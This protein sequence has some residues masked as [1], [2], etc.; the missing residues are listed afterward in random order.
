MSS[1]VVYRASGQQCGEDLEPFVKHPAAHPRVWL[2]AE[3]T[4]LADPVV[5]QPQAEHEPATREHRQ[6]GCLPG[7]DL[8]SAPRQRGHHRPEQQP[9]GPHRDGRATGPHVGDRGDPL[10]V[11]HVVPDEEPVPAGRL[12]FG[13]Q[14]ADHPWVGQGIEGGNEEPA[15]RGHGTIMPTAPGCDRQRAVAR[16]LGLA[17]RPIIE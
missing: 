12:G 3:R 8:W 1:L 16:G 10:A 7:Q 14:V 4:E 11:L 13:S 2:V 9:L 17:V 5:T 6:A 15:A